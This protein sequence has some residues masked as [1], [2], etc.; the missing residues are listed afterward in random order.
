MVAPACAKTGLK[1][2]FATRLVASWRQDDCRIAG[3]A[4]E[5]AAPLREDRPEG[6][7]AARPAGRARWAQPTAGHCKKSEGNGI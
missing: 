4:T 5:R 6:L 1:R 3:G 2:E 7:Q